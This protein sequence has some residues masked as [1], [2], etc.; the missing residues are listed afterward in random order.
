MEDVKEASGFLYRSTWNLI[1]RVDLLGMVIFLK[2]VTGLSRSL[3]DDLPELFVEACRTL[4]DFVK[5]RVLMIAR[6][7][8]MRP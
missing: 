2:F 1:S 5:P 8:W 6:R 7:G 3:P 4:S